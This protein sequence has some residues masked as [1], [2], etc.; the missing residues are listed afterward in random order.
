MQAQLRINKLKNINEEENCLEPSP[1]K[2]TPIDKYYFNVENN[3]T[4]VSNDQKQRNTS[5]NSNIKNQIYQSMI[6]SELSHENLLSM[7]LEY[8]QKESSK[9]SEDVQNKPE[10]D[11]NRAINNNIESNSTLDNGIIDCYISSP[12]TQTIPVDFIDSLSN[13][14]TAI[15]ID[16]AAQILEYYDATGNGLPKE[17]WNHLQQLNLR[18]QTHSVQH[19][20]DKTSCG[21]LCV[22]FLL[23][24]EKGYSFELIE[25]MTVST[26]QINNQIKN[27]SQM[28]SE[29]DEIIQPE[30]NQRWS[31]S[32]LYFILKKLLNNKN[33]IVLGPF[34]FRDYST[35]IPNIKKNINKNKIINTIIN[36]DLRIIKEFL[37]INEMLIPDNLNQNCKIIKQNRL[38]ME[39]IEQQQLQNS[40][41]KNENRIVIENIKKEEKLKVQKC[42]NKK[43]QEQEINKLQRKLTSIEKRKLRLE[44]RNSNK[45]LAND[46]IESDHS[47]SEDDDQL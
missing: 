7:N 45:A 43:K 30:K 42:A 16:T 21:P 38:M 14:W 17:I 46:I 15:R 44:I 18:V 31:S 27:W 35:Y 5:E 1:N 25:Q 23:N 2:S 39:N 10:N 13:H 28:F 32:Q 22:L 34:D 6:H 24:K 9:S 4:S 12:P 41:E 11:K 8:L 37:G 47:N 33:N 36:I 19:Q 26:N 29:Q 20:R 3:V 40:K